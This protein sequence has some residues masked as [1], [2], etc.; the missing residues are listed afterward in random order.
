MN[1][2]TPA[3]FAR[4]RTARDWA[5]ADLRQLE[6]ALR[7]LGLFRAKAKVLKGAGQALLARFGGRV[8]AARAELTLLPGVG[9]KTA[10]VVAMHLGSEAALPVDTHV[11]R[12]AYRLALSSSTA[13]D[14]IERDLS[15]LLPAERW[16]VAHHALI[17]HGR[18]ICLARRPACPDCPVDALCPKRGV[19]SRK[20]QRAAGLGSA[21]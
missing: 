10:G 1:T 12:L 5:R 2:V 7:S 18:T 15:A 20:R 4:Y 17:W 3:L 19:K 14:D 13:P 16:K 8:P 6:E 9:N 11:A 21:R